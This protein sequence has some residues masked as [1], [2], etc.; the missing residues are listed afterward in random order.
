MASQ[1]GIVVSNNENYYHKISNL[2]LVLP[3]L[4]KIIGKVVS[5]QLN[6]YLLVNNLHE[7]FQSAYKSF[8]SCETALLRVNN[9]ILQAIDNRQCVV[10]LLLDLS[11]AFDT[12]DHSIL[13]NRLEFKF[14]IRGSVLAWFKSY[15]S[16]RCQFV[17]IDGVSSS[18]KN[19]YCGVPQGS[20]LGPILYLLYTSP[21]SNILKRHDMCFHFYAD[22]TQIYTTFSTNNSNNDVQLTIQRINNCLKDVDNWMSINKLK[23][24]KDKTELLYFYSKYNTQNLQFPSIQFGSDVISP[25][26]FARN[27]GVLFDSTLSLTH[28]I[29]QLSKSAFYHLKNIA[30]IRRFLSFATTEKLIHAFITSKID[31]YNSLLFGLPKYSIDKIQYIQNAAAR[32]VTL[33]R[34]H[35]H[36]TPLLKQLH[37]LPVTERI[38][39]KILLLTFKA[40]HHQSPQYINDMI[41]IYKPSRSLRSSNSLLLKPP[42]Y[43]LK[44]YGCRSFSFAA[45]ELWNSLPLSLRSCSSVPEFKSQLKTYLF[46][47]YFD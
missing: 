2:P 16:N 8:H 24:N 23:L 17:S 41:T 22:D 31:N 42:Y 6:D 25:S 20:V 43:N 10:L 21:I 47:S 11:A 46:K 1:Q 26:P 38:K 4:S 30:R 15:L 18:T 29:K 36:I 32:L 45:P 28:H 12:V 13:L 27:I 14:G 39:Y 5:I 3:D 19:L 40:L 9:D 33:S 7:P 37:W 34:K 44:T 35:D